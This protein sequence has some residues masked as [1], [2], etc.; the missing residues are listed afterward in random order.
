MSFKIKDIKND[1]VV[2]PWYHSKVH[3]LE[4]DEEDSVMEMGVDGDMRIIAHKQQNGYKERFR[5]TNELKELSIINENGMISI[6]N[7]STNELVSD[8]IK[9]SIIKFVENTPDVIIR[10]TVTLDDLV[11]Y[12][13]SNILGKIRH[14]TDLYYRMVLYNIVV[15]SRFYK[16]PLYRKAAN[17]VDVPLILSRSID[18]MGLRV[19]GMRI[20]KVYRALFK[21]MIYDIKVING[22]HVARVGFED[23]DLNIINHGLLN[24]GV[25]VFTNYN[26]FRTVDDSFIKLLHD[27][28]DNEMALVFFKDFIERFLINKIVDNIIKTGSHHVYLYLYD[29]IRENFP[30]V[31]LLV[32]SIPPLKLS[33]LVLTE[34]GNGN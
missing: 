12:L 24:H 9:K 28:C 8:Y 5:G 6:L 14:T 27:N 4:K 3:F 34:V 7:R 1:T 26:E 33:K 23:H 10:R 17:L 19:S 18:K 25:E 31:N 2:L 32:D 20:S 22:I 29:H 15:F 13:E 21:M 11:K 30:Y 16:H